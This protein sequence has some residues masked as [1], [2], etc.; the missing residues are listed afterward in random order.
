MHSS[1]TISN[2][3]N[4]G[5]DKIKIV[6]SDSKIYYYACQVCLN[7]GI[8]DLQSTEKC[9][10]CIF[11]QVRGIIR[12]C[13]GSPRTTQPLFRATARSRRAEA[14]AANTFRRERPTHPTQHD[15]PRPRGRRQT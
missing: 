3:E 9:T 12:P 4:C 1:S 11:D 10:D 6:Q 7:D 5:S 15:Q 13:E 8:A 14:S 2:C